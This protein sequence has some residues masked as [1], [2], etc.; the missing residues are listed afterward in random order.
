MPSTQP[1]PEP[2]PGERL[3]A[4]AAG[5][6][7]PMLGE[8]SL[9]LSPGAIQRDRYLLSVPADLTP[10]QVVALA[11]LTAG[12]GLDVGLFANTIAADLPRATTL[13]FGFE[14]GAAGDVLKLYCEF[15]IA[16]A[17]ATAR[18]ERRPLLVHRAVKWDPAN[19]ARAAISRYSANP[20]LTVPETAARIATLFGDNPATT[21]AQTL[22]HRAAGRLAALDRL[23]L[24][25]EEQGTPRR[26][27]D[28]KLYDAGFTTADLASSLPALAA[29]FG[30]PP[31]E[32]P[33][34]SLGHLAGGQGRDGRPFL[35]LY[36]GGGRA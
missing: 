16:G 6:G 34:A 10:T 24:E 14:S 12:L 26:S 18:A 19:P 4:F 13:H 20:S 15:P 30:L 3:H 9:K 22:V 27:F 33:Q 25:V 2:T 31:I 32:L 21:L 11:T 17:W 23:F 35:T 7:L 29:L 28:L 5:L 1:R 36:Y 8:S